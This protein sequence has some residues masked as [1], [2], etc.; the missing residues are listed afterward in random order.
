MRQRE[1]T[2]IVY[3]NIASMSENHDWVAVD[4]STYGGEP[5][6]PV[7]YGKTAREAIENLM[8]RLEL[9]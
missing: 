5:T 6:D 8:E 9:E 2:I 1:Y 7:G 3:R 4:D